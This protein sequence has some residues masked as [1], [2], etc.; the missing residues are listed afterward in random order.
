MV[1]VGP[2]VVIGLEVHEEL[3]H[4]RGDS[5]VLETLMRHNMV[6][7][8]GGV[9][10]REQD[11]AIAGVCLRKGFFTPLPPI[12]GIALVLQQIANGGVLQAV[13]RR[14]SAPGGIER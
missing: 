4:H 10:D 2:F 7:T 8:A 9:A 5:W 11:G 6:P 13:H 3:V 1:G 14:N 12:D